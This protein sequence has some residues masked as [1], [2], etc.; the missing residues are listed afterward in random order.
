MMKLP[1]ASLLLVLAA[2]AVPPAPTPVTLPTSALPEGAGDPVRGAILS[3]AFVFGQPSS[4]AGNPG[5]AAT[6]LGQVEFLAVELAGPRWIGV[7]ALVVPMLAQA[8]DEIRATFGFAP[9]PPQAAIDAL[10]GAAEALRRND[11][12]A[13]TRALAPLAPGA[14]AATL[15]RLVALPPLPLTAQATARANR[16]LMQRNQGHGRRLLF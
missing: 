2:C 13:A 4:V 1:A 15:A 8:R 16:V 12:A 3:S 7:D 9:I 10:F 6:A 11:P 14:E 5:A